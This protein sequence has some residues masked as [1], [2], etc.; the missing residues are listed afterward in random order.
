MRYCV[1]RLILATDSGGSRPPIPTET[2]RLFFL[3][4]HLLRCGGVTNPSNDHAWVHACV[5]AIV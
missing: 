3:L 5:N 4:P 2:D 1:S